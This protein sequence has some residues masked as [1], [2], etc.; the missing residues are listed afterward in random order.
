M[1]SCIECEK[2]RLH[3]FISLLGLVL[4]QTSGV[5]GV[6]SAW[7]AQ[8]PVM[9]GIVKQG[10]WERAEKRTMLQHGWV[11]FQH[12][13]ATL[14]ILVDLVEDTHNDPPQRGAPW[15]D[16]LSLS[17]DVDRN[18]AITPNVDLSYGLYPGRY[19]LGVQ[20][21][22]RA[23]TWTGLRRTNA[24]LGA[25][26]GSSMN[27]PA[28]HRIW[29]IA[30]PFGEIRAGLGQSVRLGIKAHSQT[31]TFDDVLPTDL[32]RDF[33]N[34]LEVSLKLPQVS[35]GTTMAH[36]RERFHVISAFGDRDRY[37]LKLTQPGRLKLRA[38]WKGTAQTLALIL[39]GPGQA[40]YY[41]RKDGRSPLEIDFQLTPELLQR[42]DQWQVSIINFSRQGSAEGTLFM[43]HPVKRQKLAKL[44]PAFKNLRLKGLK[45]GPAPSGTIER[46]FT[47]DGSVEIR[48]PD[49]TV[50]RIYDG[51][52]TIV[53]SDGTTM[54]ALYSHVQPDTPPPL[55][56]DDRILAW[57]EWSNDSLLDFIRMLVENDQTA[58]GYYLKREQE[59]AKTVY[60][61]MRMRTSVVGQLLMPE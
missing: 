4:V 13:R 40:G 16:Y 43:E 39:N 48:Y 6:D 17:V 47:E 54:T 56:S 3:L 58:V 14:Y 20:T 57:L 35:L 18:R 24:R 45:V 50:K 19:E 53:R 60:D 5:R 61:K 2:M 55:P 25:G 9:D 27:S 44:T 12:D 33:S 26:F 11:F 30:I 8:P 59:K 37:Q 15:G 1:D 31:P 32:S 51:G 21:Y 7:V 41:A 49:G 46:T 38:V 23:N 42:G 52:F 22:L 34:L 28:A 29:E 36:V 10:E